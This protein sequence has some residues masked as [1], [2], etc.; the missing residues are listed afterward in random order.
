MKVKEI[1][2]EVIDQIPMKYG[3]AANFAESYNEGNELTDGEPF[4][5]WA[6]LLK[7][8]I[9]VMTEQGYDAEDVLN[10]L[11]EDME[12]IDNLLE[13]EYLEQ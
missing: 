12:I 9:T 11:Q 8:V 1:V 2:S 6:E 4:P 7:A 5:E 3:T 10:S 13:T